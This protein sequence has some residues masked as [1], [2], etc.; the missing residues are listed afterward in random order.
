MSGGGYW[1]ITSN[2]LDVTDE[3]AV[4]NAIQAEFG[5][6][7]VPLDWNDLVNYYNTYSA[8]NGSIWPL[9]QLKKQEEHYNVP[10][11]GITY[12]GAWFRTG[13]EA[14]FIWEEAE[15]YFPTGGWYGTRGLKTRSLD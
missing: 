9:T 6:T 7:A 5:P 12:N 8:V 2:D 11:G 13:N 4:R 15:Y 10:F 14:W 3:T 1:A